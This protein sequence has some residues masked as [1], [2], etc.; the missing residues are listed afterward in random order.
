MLASSDFS[1]VRKLLLPSIALFA[2]ACNAL[3]EKETTPTSDS[4]IIPVNEAASQAAAKDNSSEG[5]SIEIKPFDKAHYDFLYF[6]EH[7]IIPRFW[8][9]YPEQ[10]WAMLEENGRDELVHFFNACE[11]NFDTSYPNDK[12]QLD[13][14]PFSFDYGVNGWIITLPKPS[15]LTLCNYVAL[16]HDGNFPRYITSEYN[17]TDGKAKW[18]LCE[19]GFDFRTLETDKHYNYGQKDMESKESFVRELDAF[20]SQQYRKPE[21][22]NNTDS[23]TTDTSAK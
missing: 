14:E 2:L 21:T 15:G 1:S 3:A 8:F 10:L 6:Y 11:E 17:D 19:W 4:A 5:A 18:F 12:T 9:S 16:V 23:S 13:V 20:L 7:H 22:I